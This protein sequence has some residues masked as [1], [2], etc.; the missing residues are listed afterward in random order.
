MTPSEVFVLAFLIGLLS[1]LRSMTPIAVVAWGA[2]RGLLHLRGTTLA[3]LHSPVAAIIFTI[4]ALIEL[5]A[6]K[7]PSTPSRTKPAGLIARMALGG[8][9]GAAVAFSGGQALGLGWFLGAAAGLAGAFL[10]YEVRTRSVKALKVPDLAVAL[11]ED[12]VAIGGSILVV[13]R[14]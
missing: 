10:G 5:V 2:N 1:G 9:A 8:L 7:L 12:I 6:D 4:L 11:V 14:F 13:T 3:F